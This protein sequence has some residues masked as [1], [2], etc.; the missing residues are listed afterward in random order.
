MLR[1]QLRYFNVDQPIKRVLV[2]SA[3]QREG[4]SFIAL[5]LARAAVSTGG[6]RTLLIEADLRQ[7]SLGAA[8]GLSA[9]AGL[10]E[11]LTQ[12]ADLLL[13]LRELVVPLDAADAEFS[14]TVRCDVLLGGAVP[15]NP[16]Q[17]LASKGMA[18]LLEVAGSVYELVVIDAPP[19]GIISD[20]ISLV[21][22]V[23][24]VVVVT[25]LGY[26]SRD[27]ARRLVTQLRELN[28]HVL[29]LAINGSRAPATYSGSAYY[30]RA[31][32]RAVDPRDAAGPS[33]RQ[34]E[35]VDD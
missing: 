29:G 12:S 2:T 15:P 7:P 24:G 25:R 8:L 6:K 1:A 27:D 18:E 23:D 22:Q 35:L 32:P 11:L 9:T 3:E 26:S 10:A 33:A 17:L 30:T 19:L 34:R 14:R 21:H 4:K 31:R 13:G 28:A 20:A 5:N 16:V